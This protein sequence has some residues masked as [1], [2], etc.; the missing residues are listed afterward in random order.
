VFSSTSL[1]ASLQ[2]GAWLKVIAAGVSSYAAT[3]LKRTA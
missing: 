2:A 1:P 3:N